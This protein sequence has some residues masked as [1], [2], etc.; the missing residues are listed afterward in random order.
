MTDGFTIEDYITK[1]R[2]NS[3]TGRTGLGGYH[4]FSIVKAYGG[5][6]NLSSDPNWPFIVDILI[7]VSSSETSKF[8][9]A[10]DDDCV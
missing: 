2:F 3:E 4:V 10:Y 7:P 8:D 6:L 9:V 1:G 5:F